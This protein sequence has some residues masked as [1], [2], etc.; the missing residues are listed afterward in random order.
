MPRNYIRKSKRDLYGSDTLRE[1]LQDIEKGLSLTAAAKKYKI[2]RKTLR[3]HRDKKVA[4]PGTINLGRY[5][6]EFNKEFEVALTEK[7]KKHRRTFVFGLTVRNI[8]KLVID[9]A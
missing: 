8:C 3:R 2:D 9:L 4:N 1:A 7:I 5:R 6:P